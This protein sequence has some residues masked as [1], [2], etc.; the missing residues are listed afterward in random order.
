MENILNRILLFFKKE[1]FVYLSGMTVLAV[2]AC[3]LRIGRGSIS[4]DEV[5]TIGI[6]RN[7][8]VMLNTLWTQEGNMWLYSFLMYFWL[9]LGTSEFMLRS[10]SAIFAVLTVPAFYKLAQETNGNKIAKIATPLFILNFYFIFYA[11]MARGYSLTLLMVTLSGLYFIKFV[12]NTSSN[13]YLFF[14]AIFTVLAIYSHLLAGL[15]IFS[16]YIVLLLIPKRIPWK[17]IVLATLGI[18]IFLLPLISSP[19]LRGHQLDWLQKPPFIH[20]PMGVVMLGGDSVLFTLLGSLVI[21]FLLWKKRNIIFA[22]NMERFSLFW[23]VLWSGFPI[24]SG[25]IFSWIIKPI[26]EPESFNICLPA[27]ILLISVGLEQIKRK[28]LYR[29]IFILLILFSVFRLS[30]WYL[31]QSYQQLVMENNDS[32]N[33]KQAAEYVASHDKS[34]DVIIFYAYYIRPPFEYYFDKINKNSLKLIEISKDKYALGGGTALP[35]PNIKLLD[36]LHTLHQRVWLILSYNDFSWLGRRMQW[37][38]TE[39]EL[40]KYYIVI[41]DRKLAQ[42]EIKLFE[43]K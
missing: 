40:N 26:Y 32:R 36:D 13:K 38:E 43:R 17:K 34:K 18:F 12:K 27:Y 4:L 6:S 28:W 39:R 30:A 2:I 29:V 16:G 31:G 25:F 15:V 14:Y 1:N 23:L 3:F 7:W 8:Q 20:L 21:V 19:A 9:K 42:I 37:Q 22:K 24:L 35:E 33:W 11:Q 41:S 10:L 5:S